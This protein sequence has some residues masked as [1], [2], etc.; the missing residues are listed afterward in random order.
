MGGIHLQYIKQ[1]NALTEGFA[2]TT[3][4]AGPVWRQPITP[5]RDAV[6]TFIKPYPVY[7]PEAVYQREPPSDIPAMV[8]REVGNSRLV[9]MAGDVDS[10]FWRL[11][12]MDLGRQISNAVRWLLKGNNAVDVEGD[13]LMEVIAWET[14]RG[15]AVH[16]LNYNGANAFRG[17]MR[18]PVPLTAQVVR[19][20]VPAEKKIR[21]ASLLHAGTHIEFQRAGDHVSLIVP[22]VEMYE[23]VALE[24]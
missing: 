8:S 9:Y 12:H 3:W 18:K 24:L 20:M 23:V 19:V 6:M 17:H 5:L 21:K 13:G 15:F 11:D 14:Q 1:R 16:L 4:I 7:P 22:K 2:E 10:S